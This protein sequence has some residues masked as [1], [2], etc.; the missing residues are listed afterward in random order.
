[1]SDAEDF[2]AQLLRLFAAF[3][4][5][6]TDARLAAYREGLKQMPTIS[7][8]RVINALTGENQPTE[9]P[10]PRDIWSRY[11]S[12]RDPAR[13]ERAADAKS[14]EIKTDE[15]ESLSH[16]LL[17]IH[18]AAQKGLGTKPKPEGGLH[19]G[20]EL[21]DCMHE[22]RELV[23]A[24]R[25]GIAD[26]TPLTPRWFVEQW[27]RALDRV[28]PPHHDE[29]EIYSRMICNARA[30]LPFTQGEYSQGKTNA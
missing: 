16:Q 7:L 28:S 5:P 23:L 9:F 20:Q 8:A 10:K 18:V 17:W 22:R 4:K 14:A 26:G 15:I 11:R 3:D 6:A 19:I 12:L 21:A 27:I 13:G 1:M 24:A 30:D 25:E 2:D 29:R